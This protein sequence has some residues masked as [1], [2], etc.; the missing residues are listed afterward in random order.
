LSSPLAARILRELTLQLKHRTFNDQGGLLKLLPGAH[1]FEVSAIMDVARK[2]AMQ[3]NT[4]PGPLPREWFLPG[5]HVWFAWWEPPGARFGVLLL[6]DDCR[7]FGQFIFACIDGENFGARP[8][9]GFDFNDR[10]NPRL[11]S[12]VWPGKTRTK[13]ILLFILLM[14]PA[15]CCLINI[16][17]CCSRVL[18]SSNKNLIKEL[19]RRGHWPL[20][21]WNEIKINIDRWEQ[22]VGVIGERTRQHALHWV[23][24]YERRINGVWTQVSESWRGDASLRV[25][26]SRYLAVRDPGGPPAGLPAFYR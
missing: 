22:D 26:N 16:P 23:R 1:C 5:R 7:K 4:E 25:F 2:L 12:P 24:A 8:I 3:L 18:R 17:K 14:L 6:A 15:I 9:G 11:G 19:N 20:L 10:S 13:K 21:G